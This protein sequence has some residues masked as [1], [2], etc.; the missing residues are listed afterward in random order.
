MLMAISREDTDNDHLGDCKIFLEKLKNQNIPHYVTMKGIIAHYEGDL[1]LA[2]KEFV[3]NIET[4]PLSK[5]NLD[6]LFYGLEKPGPQQNP[7]STLLS[8][9]QNLMEIFHEPSNLIKD[10][11]SKAL[12]SFMNTPVDSKKVG[13]NE[14]YRFHNRVNNEKLFFAKYS[15]GFESLTEAQLISYCEKTFTTN[16]YRYY[17]FKDWVIRY[18]EKNIKTVYLIQ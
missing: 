16:L 10:T 15:N 9:P 2:R 18:D 13:G 17:T 14:Y 7:L 8:I 12:N 3:K 1:E 4:F 5:R 11:T 6:R